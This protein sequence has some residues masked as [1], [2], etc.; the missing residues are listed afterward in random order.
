VPRFQINQYWSVEAAGTI[1]LS[2]YYPLAYAQLSGAVG[3]S[4]RQFTLWSRAALHTGTLSYLG[5][6]GW[7]VNTGLSYHFVRR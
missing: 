6:P 2:S 1:S 7:T 4:R 5:M 3:V